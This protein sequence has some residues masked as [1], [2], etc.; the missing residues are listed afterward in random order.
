[1][2]EKC[3]VIELKTKQGNAMSWFDFVSYAIDGQSY[4]RF[5]LIRMRKNVFHGIFIP[6]SQ[7]ICQ[8]ILIISIK[9]AN[10]LASKYVRGYNCK[11]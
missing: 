8:H 5:C 11:Q 1:M 4:N 2:E 9:T 6:V 10:H 7:M 3:F